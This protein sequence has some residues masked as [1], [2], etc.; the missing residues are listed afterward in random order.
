MKIEELIAGNRDQE[1]ILIHGTSIP[2]SSLKKL[3]DA[4]YIHLQPYPEEKTFS[5]WGKTCSACFT[6]QDLRNMA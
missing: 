6:G 5:M 1:D 2:A 3:M 4:G